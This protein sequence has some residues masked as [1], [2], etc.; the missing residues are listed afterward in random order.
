MPIHS[1][2]VYLGDCYLASSPISL[3][4]CFRFIFMILLITRAVYGCALSI[5]CVCVI[6]RI[7]LATLI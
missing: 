6:V 2:S 3:T 5:V 1:P 4:Y 7:L